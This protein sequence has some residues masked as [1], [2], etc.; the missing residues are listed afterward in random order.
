MSILANDPRVNSIQV[1]H[2]AKK[3]TVHAAAAPRNS[4]TARTARLSLRRG[5]DGV[6]GSVQVSAVRNLLL[7]AITNPMAG[8]VLQTNQKSRAPGNKTQ[9]AINLL[10]DEWTARPIVGS[11]SNLRK[12]GTPRN[13]GLQNWS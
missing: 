5:I 12:R 7:T 11:L 1:V 6:R 3:A 10:P 9:V 4:G 2:W 13:G 8:P